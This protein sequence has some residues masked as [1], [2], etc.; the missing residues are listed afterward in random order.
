MFLI[1]EYRKECSI[2]HMP[3]QYDYLLCKYE[4]PKIFQLNINNIN[5]HDLLCFNLYL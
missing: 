1:H 2:Q 3:S 4:N 5:L